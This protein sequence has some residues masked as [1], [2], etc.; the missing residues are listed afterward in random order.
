MGT[1]QDRAGRTGEWVWLE[2]L[3]RLA[4]P[5]GAVYEVRLGPGPALLKAFLRGGAL[6]LEEVHSDRDVHL[7]GRAE[8]LVRPVR[9]RSPEGVVDPANGAT[10]TLWELRGEHDPRDRALLVSWGC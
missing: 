2:Y 9:R 1:R 10:G 3:E 7:S 8:D 5:D 6:L 4:S